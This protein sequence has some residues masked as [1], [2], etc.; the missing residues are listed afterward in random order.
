MGVIPIRKEA[1]HKSEMISQLLFGEHYKV[2]SYSDDN[3]WVSIENHYDQYTGWVA[4]NQHNEISPEYFDQVTES[5][6]KICLDIFSTILYRKSPITIPIGSIIPISTNELFKMEERL[7]FAGEAK[8]LRQKRE[9]EYIKQVALKFLNAPYLWGG[10]TPLGIDCSGFVQVVFKIGGFE[11]YRD[12]SQQVEQGVEIKGIEACIPGDLAFFKNS[13]GSVDHVGI[14]IEDNKI[15]HA[16]G[17]VRI[18][19][20]SVDGITDKV[21]GLVT[22][23]DMLFRRI[24]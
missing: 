24:I 4:A 3:K 18:D 19:N 20:L 6:Y 2:L 10:R 17:R 16:S 7:A 11:L 8:S 14:I 1:S 21:T 13:N 22:H 15:L 23:S 9:F 12:T 5:D